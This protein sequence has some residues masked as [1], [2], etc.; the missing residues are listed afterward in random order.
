MKFFQIIAFNAP[1]SLLRKKRKKVTEEEYTALIQRHKEKC[2]KNF[3]GKSEA[4]E[5]EAATRIWGRSKE[6]NKMRY[7]KFIGDGDSSAYLAVKKLN[8]YG[9]VPVQKEECI[10]HVRKR[11][12]TRLRKLKE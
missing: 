9:N 3:E 12:G 10:N 2:Q 1:G 8:P 6:L 7:V 5:A 4:M 11:L